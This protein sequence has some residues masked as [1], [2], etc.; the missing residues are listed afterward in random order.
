METSLM[1]HLYPKFVNISS[2]P[3]Q[4]PI[5]SP[6]YDILPPAPHAALGLP[7]VRGKSICHQAQAFA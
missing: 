5:T 6:P 1:S 2:V 7:A 3:E 4:S